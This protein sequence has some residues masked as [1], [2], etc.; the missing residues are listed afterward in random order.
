MIARV[1]G[2]VETAAWAFQRSIDAPGWTA[3]LPH[4]RVDDLRIFRF[5]RKVGRS[6]V[7]AFVQNVL[8]SAASVGGTIDA[9]CGIRTVGVAE[10]GDEDDIGVRGMNEDAADLPGI[11][12]TDVSPSFSGVGGF[13][14]A[15]ALR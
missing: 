6:D 14:H 4:R 3:R 8:P 15:V 2:F 7:W 1:G 9:A 12:Q 5:E 13:V 10:R 11:A